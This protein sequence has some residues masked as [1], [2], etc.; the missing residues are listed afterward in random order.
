MIKKHRFRHIKGNQKNIKIDRTNK[1]SFLE[2][3]ISSNNT[4]TRNIET[5]TPIGGEN[6]PDWMINQLEGMGYTMD[7]LEDIA[8]GLRGNVIVPVGIEKYVM[9]HSSWRPRDVSQV[10]NSLIREYPKFM[11]T[12]LTSLNDINISP[13]GIGWGSAGRLGL[14]LGAVLLLIKIIT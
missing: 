10:Y 2:N 9:N 8:N 7:I 11:T 13:M 6:I 5:G 1:G 3:K 12:L 4:T 14:K